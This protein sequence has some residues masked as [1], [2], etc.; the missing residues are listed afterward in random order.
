M[1][2]PIAFLLWR[3]MFLNECWQ[4]KVSVR[5]I[6]QKCAIVIVEVKAPGERKEN[7]RTSWSTRVHQR[8][9]ERDIV[10]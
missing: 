6:D 2:I 9:C 7:G 8:R 3:T 1:V 4:S 10:A 5:G